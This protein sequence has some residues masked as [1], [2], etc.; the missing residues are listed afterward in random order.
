[1]I[2][3]MLARDYE[4]RYLNYPVFIQPKYDG[5]RAIWNGQEF[6]SR[7][8]KSIVSVPGIIESLQTSFDGFPLDGELYSNSGGFSFISSVVRKTK[9]VKDDDSIFYVVYDMPVMNLS[10]EDRFE[11]LKKKVNEVNHPRV[12]LSETVRIDNNLSRLNV[13]SDKYEGTMIRNA[14]GL[15]TFGKRSKDLLKVKDM[16]DTEAVVIGTQ[17]RVSYTKNIVDPLTPGSKAYSDGTYYKNSDPVLLDRVGALV[18]RLDNGVEFE[19]G[20]GIN[21]ATS[22]EWYNNPP[23][24]KVVTFQYQELTDDGKPRFPVFLRFREDL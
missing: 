22:I 13:F 3:C 12:I 11:L 24:G 2:K 23:I 10:F 18:C 6:H 8:L 4:D 9:N 20:T 14:S 16:K 19:I 5:H 15:Y 1:M 17:R 21:E 7:N